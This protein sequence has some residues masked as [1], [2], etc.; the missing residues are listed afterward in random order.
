MRSPSPRSGWLIK[1]I[2]SAFGGSI[3]N[4]ALAACTLGL[5]TW[6]RRHDSLPD[7]PVVMQVPAALFDDDATSGVNLSAP[8]RIGFPVQIDDP[9]EV[10]LDIH[11][12]TDT[13]TTSSQDVTGL[14]VDFAHLA[15]LLPPS[16][17]HAGV[18][19]STRLPWWQ[20][21]RRPATASSPMFRGRQRHVTAAGPG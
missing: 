17:L 4:V 6:L 10:L 20:R 1:T 8:A 21:F 7:R 5:R 19:L 11:S 18:G 13:W 2:A 9:V 12:A 15:A 14:G 3:S 16:V